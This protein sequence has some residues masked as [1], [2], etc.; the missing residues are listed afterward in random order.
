MSVQDA[1]RG[2]GFTFRKLVG[3]LVALGFMLFA[4]SCLVAGVAF[5]SSLEA[6]FVTTTLAGLLGWAAKSWGDG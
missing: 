6:T 3:Y 5:G 2:T 4:V 1:S